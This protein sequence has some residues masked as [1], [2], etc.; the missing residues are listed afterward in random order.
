VVK[1]IVL[2]I[3]DDPVD[4][5]AAQWLLES[6]D[7][8][9]LP[10]R[11][12]GDGLE[13]LKA[14]PVD[15]V[16]SDVRMPG[17]SG[18]DVV[19]AVQTAH[20]GL[21]VVLITG[22]GDIRSAVQA[23]KLGAFDYVAKPPDEDE[24]RMAIER[25]MEYSRLKRENERLR[26]E[27]G[28][29]GIY[30]DGMIGRGAAMAA[31]FD[32]IDRVARTDSTVL[33]TGETGTG[34][35]LVARTLHYRSHRAKKPLVALNCAS[36]NPN[37]IESEL[38]GHE[39]GAFT[40]SVA[41]RR[42]RFE[43]ADGGT[44]FLDEISEISPELQAKLL[45]V[46][47][48]GDF[49]RLGSSRQLHADVR[50]IASSNRNLE[51][52]VKAGRFRQDLF[53]RLQVI[54]IRLPSLRERREDIE[55]L[56]VHFAGV[57]GRRYRTASVTISREGVEWLSRQDWKGNVRELQHAVERAVV[58]SDG[59]TLGPKDFL[60]AGEVSAEAATG[61]LQAALDVRTRECVKEALDRAQ[62][63]KQHAA[64][65]LG[66]DRVTLYRLLKRHGMES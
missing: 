16:V 8:E 57:Y 36:L 49:E 23:M 34:K 51:D 11:S 41:A 1:S 33:V 45:R 10:V 48:E 31:V 62:G 60:P 55:M 38:F 9:V 58:L 64:D 61:K 42:G 66:V 21:P 18:E 3:D 50:I 65:W 59:E 30:G 15:I 24:F 53:Y 19:K 28:A 14:S 29:G 17:M 35:E 13:K 5:K 22:H 7:Y 25:A 4:I 32:L 39:K 12:G 26:A 52:E 56:A 43:E 37:L 47:Q 40:G 27:L 6:W 54:P 2:L 20:P 46:L 44:L 63:C